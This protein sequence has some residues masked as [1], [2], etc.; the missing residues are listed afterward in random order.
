MVDESFDDIFRMMD[1]IFG[2]SIED[3]RHMLGRYTDSKYERIMDKD[4]I[5]YTFELMDIEKDDIDIKPTVDNL[6][7]TI[8]RKGKEHE[9]DITLPYSIIPKKTKVTFINGNLDITVIID[10]DK[11]NRVEIEG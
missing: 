6:Y 8:T 9:H 3:K 7:I 10:P 2:R 5:Y 11:S 4:K 1:R